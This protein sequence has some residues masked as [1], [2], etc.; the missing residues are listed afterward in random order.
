MTP[1]LSTGFN[2][3]S[4]EGD[5]ARFEAE[6]AHQVELGVTGV[7]ITATGLDA[8]SACRLIPERVR[9]LRRIVSAHKLEWSLHAPIAIDL[10][11]F[12]HID[13]HRRAALASLDLAAELGTSVVVIHPGRCTPLQ[14]VN[15]RHDLMAREREVL[16]PI[17]DH[18]HSLGIAIAYENMSPNARVIAGQETSYALDPAALASQLAAL[19]HP[20]VIACLDIS[21]A[22]QGAVYWNLDMIAACT[23]LAPHVG[24]I[25]FSDSTGVPA[26]IACRHA[27]ETAFFGLGDMHAP[28]GYGSVDFAAL[29]T[30]L[31][32]HLH[33]RT[34]IVIELR[35]HYRTHAERQTLEAAH[36]WADLLQRQEAA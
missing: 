23:A 20:G 29:A 28:P 35:E 27:G 30:A 25:H 7:E 36:H 22:Q 33:P 10:M 1:I 8:V 11:D 21:H 3:G 5:L 14:L 15:Q 19:D 17:A 18:A 13:L 4:V 6:V 16:H 32:G 12:A 26:T 2:T 24:H 9:E 34:R 31:R